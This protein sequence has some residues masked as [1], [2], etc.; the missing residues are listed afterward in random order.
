LQ[1][2]IQ[3]INNKINLSDVALHEAQL[4]EQEKV[5]L[6]QTK[7][8]SSA[9]ALIKK[10]AISSDTVTEMVFGIGKIA[11]N[12][13]LI[14]FSSKNQTYQTQDIIE[15]EEDTQITEV[16]LNVDFKSTFNQ[17]IQFIYRLESN[18]PIVFIES[19]LFRRDVQNPKINTVS[20][21]LS[22]L[23]QTDLS[24]KQVAQMSNEPVN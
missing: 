6:Q 3:Q 21:D 4:S 13:S 8:Y 18:Q 16:W 14:G 2:Q 22:F 9:Q 19:L 12:L 24:S 15:S 7:Q 10:F 17:F 5:Q 11:S 20:L 23:K 1:L